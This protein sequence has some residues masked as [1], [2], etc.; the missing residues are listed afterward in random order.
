MLFKEARRRERR[1]RLGVVGAVIVIVAGMV[2]VIAV[3]TRGPSSSHGIGSPSIESRT[4]ALRAGPIVPL[5][6]AGPLAVSSTGVLYVADQQRDQVLYRLADGQFRVIAG[7]GRH[8]FSG[9][10]G[11]ATKAE[12]SDVS[13]LTVGRDGDLYIVD[14]GR[15][16]IVNPA[17]IIRTIAGG[18]ATRSPVANGTAARSASLGAQISVALGPTGKLY[19]GTSTQLL[20]LTAE[21]TFV[22]V[23][24][25]V[26]PGLYAS[27]GNLDEF[28]QIAFDAQ[29]NIDV[30]STYAG[31]SIFQVTP[32]GVA[33][34]V[35]QARRTEGDTSVLEVAPNGIVDGENGSTVLQ[36]QGARLVPAYP[37][38]EV[39]GTSYFSLTFFAFAPNGDLYADDTD[40][41]FGPVQQLVSVNHGHVTVLW[42][43]R[44]ALDPS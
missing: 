37:F 2:V 20:R 8:G 16:R 35:G 9:D 24:A 27:P 1:R 25:V 23:P 26:P 33:T 17:G 40:G 29:G 39:P 18:G 38:N 21:G 28:A 11:L 7:D 32:G 4:G 19:I 6:D 31:W 36:I 34:Y 15:V 43:H 30:A 22:T 14:G 13:D 42:H 10:G 41:G 3:A 5:E 44:I 12:L